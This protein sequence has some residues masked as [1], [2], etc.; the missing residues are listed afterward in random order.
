MKRLV[1]LS[2]VAMLCCTVT[3]IGRATTISDNFDT[4]HN[5]ALGVAG[6]IWDGAGYNLNVT[7]T[8]NTEVIVADANI[9]NGGRL[10]VTTKY[11][12][13]EGGSAG[14][15][16]VILY[17][18]VAGD[19]TAIVQVASAQRGLFNTEGLIARVGNGTDAGGDANWVAAVMFNVHGASGGGWDDLLRMRSVDNNVESNV[20]GLAGVYQPG[21]LKLTREGDVFKAFGASDSSGAPGEWSQ[22]GSVTRSDMAGL[23]VQVGL[24]Q[25]S[26]IDTSLTAQFDNFSLTTVPE[27]ASFILLYISLI[28]LVVYAWR[29]R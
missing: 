10:T 6:T 23:T 5:Y 13:W 11:G 21:W 28:G 15:D 9:T 24:V 29:R 17:K 20:D 25:A 2:G 8:G 18:N 16:G 27:P 19:F 1:Y 14:D 4:D 12:S 7:G 3:T 26:Y 22:I